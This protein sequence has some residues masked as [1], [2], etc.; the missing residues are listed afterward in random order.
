MVRFSTA[1]FDST[2]T[3]STMRGASPT[4]WTLR[5]VACSWAGPTTTAAECVRSES[6]R[7]VSDS[8]C[9]I[10]PCALLKKD[11]TCSAASWPSGAGPTSE[12]T[13]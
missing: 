4:I 9:S 3:I 6:S 11:R 10:S 12:S 5:T 7:V 13:K 2:A 1:P 8:I